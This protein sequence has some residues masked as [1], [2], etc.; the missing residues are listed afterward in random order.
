[1][2]QQHRLTKFDKDPALR[3]MVIERLQ[4]GWSLQQIDGQLRANAGR[5]VISYETSLYL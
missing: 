1:M 2:R 5:C 4:E 3:A